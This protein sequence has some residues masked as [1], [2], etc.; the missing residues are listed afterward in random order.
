[1]NR[2]VEIKAR[3]RD[4]EN[5]DVLL[6]DR[7]EPPALLVQR[8][9]FF[10]CPSGRLKLREEAVRSA[11]IFYAR[12]SGAFARESRYWRTPVADAA[13]L[14]ALLAAALGVAGV[15][16]KQRLVFLI[17]QTRVHLDASRRSG[18][19]CRAGGRARR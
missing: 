14:K 13:G 11:L 2:N 15:V 9:T 8:D 3:V 17:G 18:Q 5:L 19:L 4:R 1:M 7:T 16:T 6:R 12:E 10:R